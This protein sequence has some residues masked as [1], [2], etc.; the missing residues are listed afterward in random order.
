MMK[1]KLFGMFWDGKEIHLSRCPGIKTEAEI[2]Y[3]EDYKIE[4]NLFDFDVIRRKINF[5]ELLSC[6]REEDFSNVTA[7]L[8]WCDTVYLVV[9]YMPKNIIRIMDKFFFKTLLQAYCF[10]Q[11]AQKTPLVVM[12]MDEKKKRR[13]MPYIEY[14]LYCE[15][16]VVA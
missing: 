5:S 6:E 2:G 13:A 10:V 8:E 1:Y 14:Y 12:V 3:C 15:K 9:D 4:R 16:P 11:S 7:R